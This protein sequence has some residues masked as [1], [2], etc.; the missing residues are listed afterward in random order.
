MLNKEEKPYMS[1]IAAIEYHGKS[2]AE[3]KPSALLQ[4]ILNKAAASDDTDMLEFMR[5]NGARQISELKVS[6]AL[7]LAIE[8]GNENAS[9]LLI[10]WGGNEI[11]EYVDPDTR[12]T[13][14]HKSAL[15]GLPRTCSLLTESSVNIDAKNKDRSTALHCAVASGNL[16]TVRILVEAGASVKIK[17]CHK[18]TAIRLARLHNK[19]DILTFLETSISSNNI[20]QSKN[21]ASDPL[22]PPSS[23]RI[24]RIE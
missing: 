6:D 3:M 12:E 19:Q 13:F 21:I 15:K 22:A 24:S 7:N 4:M 18:N 11:S 20:K 10:N 23:D 14:L 16:D 1:T 17:N 5:K 8:N 9:I 2:K